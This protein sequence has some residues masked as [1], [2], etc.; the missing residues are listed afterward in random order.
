MPM[1]SQLIISVSKIFLHLRLNFKDKTMIG[2]FT[3]ED[4]FLIIEGLYKTFSPETEEVGIVGSAT[5]IEEAMIKIPQT[6]PDIIVLDL[7][8][9]ETD[10]VAN[11]RYLRNAFPQ[12]P[13]VLLTMEDS[14]RWQIKMFRLGAMAFLNKAEKKE[15]IKNVFIQVAN[16]YAVIPD[17]VSQVLISKTT[18]PK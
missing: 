1:P 11:F 6:K 5:S 18:Y 13:I 15:T 8:I 9:N 16:G 14:L 2:L 10:P 3:I 7:F 17:K 12:I 4:H